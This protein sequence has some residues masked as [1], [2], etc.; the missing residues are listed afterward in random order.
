M[1]ISNKWL[2]GGVSVALLAAATLW[3]GVKYVPYKDMGGVLTVCMGYTG[4]DIVVNKRYTK[5]ECDGLLRTELASHGKGVLSCITR[6]LKQHQYDAF[7][8][9]SYNIGVSG[10]CNQS[11]SAKLFN[12]GYEKEACE[13]IAFKGDN[14][15]PNWSYITDPKTKKK[16]FVQGLFN[17]RLF[18]RQMC[19][20]DTIEYKT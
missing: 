1:H 14:K 20:G 19:L 13:A 2:L 12:A 7:T 18:E 15:T 6:P 16:V 8:L 3:E 10:F 4:K 17:R 5:Q 9:F 11:A